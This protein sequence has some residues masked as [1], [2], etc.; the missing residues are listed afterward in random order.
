LPRSTLPRALGAGALCLTAT[1]ATAVPAAAQTPAHAAKL[2]VSAKRMNVHIGSRVTVSGHVRSLAPGAPRPTASFQLR[3]GGHWLTLDRA[4]VTASGRYVLRERMR[5]SISAP[6]RVR[7]S[8]GATRALGRLNVYRSAQASWYGPG[9]FGQRTG[10]GGTLRA[11]Q[12]GV[13]HKTLPCGSKVTLRHGGRVVRVAVIDRG[14][15][16]GAR[17]FDLTAATA[18]KLGFRGHGAIQVAG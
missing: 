11:G 16:A 18:R 1:A 10:C 5:R 14:P 6:A 3:R 12:L 13:A 4:H 8:S 9:L 7:L 2:G 17:E 15:Y